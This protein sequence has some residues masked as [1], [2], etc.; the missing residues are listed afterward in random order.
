MIAPG[1]EASV[2]ALLPVL[3]YASVAVFALTGA[4]VASRSQLDSWGSFSSPV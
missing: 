2:S 4:L 3:D 1:L